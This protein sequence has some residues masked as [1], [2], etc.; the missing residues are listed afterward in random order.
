MAKFE[1][2]V[3]GYSSWRKVL[4]R[5]GGVLSGGKREKSEKNR[6]VVDVGGKMEQK[7]V[8]GRGVGG[9]EMQGK[10]GV[11]KGV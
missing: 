11:G 5:G 8:G 10:G 1:V 7:K 3:K 6:G 9:R 2:G 4:S